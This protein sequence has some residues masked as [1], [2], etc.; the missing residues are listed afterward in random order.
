MLFRSAPSVV[1]ARLLPL[2]IRIDPDR[3]PDVLALT[4]SLRT[5]PPVQAGASMMLPDVRRYYVDQAELAARVSRYDR[6][7]AEVVFASVADRLA[8]LDHEFMGLGRDGQAAFRAA[9]A[10]DARAARA[11][12][13]ALPP[14]P[15]PPPPGIMEA[16]RPRHRSKA[17]AR[18]MLSRTLASPPAI[19]LRAPATPAGDEEWLNEID[20]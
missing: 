18:I 11:L 7:A 8:S 1:L 14:D 4:L 13:E 16:G 3:A 17:D 12:L 15:T 2:A 20:D 19:R 5:A 10:Y 6:A 9:G